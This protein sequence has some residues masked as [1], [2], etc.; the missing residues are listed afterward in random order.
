[1]NT[2]HFSRPTLA[3]FMLLMALTL[4]C[5]TQAQQPKPTV[6]AKTAVIRKAYNEMK[7]HIERGVSQENMLYQ[8]KIEKQ[9]N[10]PAVGWVTRT[11]SIYTVPPTTEEAMPGELNYHNI[12]L[13]ITVSD[14]ANGMK[15]YYAEYL[16]DRRTGKPIFAYQYDMYKEEDMRECRFYYDNG[17]MLQCLPVMAHPNNLYVYHEAEQL[18]AMADEVEQR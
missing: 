5:S 12:T 18:K 2:T 15:R 4:P 1:M 11:I 17:T 7:A 10:Y 14:N 13:F 6:K 3:V 16:Y 8:T 9:A